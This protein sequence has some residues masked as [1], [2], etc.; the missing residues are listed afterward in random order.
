MESRPIKFVK[1]PGMRLKNEVSKEPEKN[2][3]CEDV[4]T[5]LHNTSAVVKFSPDM[6]KQKILAGNRNDGISGQFVVQYEVERDPDGG[7]VSNLHVSVLKNFAPRFKNRFWLMVV[8]S[9]IF[10]PPRI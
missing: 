5:F 4:I 1:V 9:S 3:D 6:K 10:S 7:E 2:S 8:T